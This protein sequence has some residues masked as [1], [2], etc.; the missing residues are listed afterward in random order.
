MYGYEWILIIAGIVL[1]IINIA[2]IVKFFGV[3]RNIELLTQLF[4]DGK[5]PAF[6]PNTYERN[7]YVTVYYNKKGAPITKEEW[8]EEKKKDLEEGKKNVKRM[9]FNDTSN[10]YAGIMK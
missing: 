2:M 10:P 1:L 3:A 5:K 9:D 6:D 8:I 7:E 4:I